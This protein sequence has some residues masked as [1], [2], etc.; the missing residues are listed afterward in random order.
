MKQ[1]SLRH[2]NGNVSVPRGITHTRFIVLLPNLHTC[3]KHQ[4]VSSTERW[5]C[6]MSSLVSKFHL[7]IHQT[8]SALISPKNAS[9][10]S[11][12]KVDS[13][14]TG[15]GPATKNTEQSLCRGSHSSPEKQLCPHTST[16]EFPP[17]L[18]IRKGEKWTRMYNRCDV[19]KNSL[20]LGAM[21]LSFSDTFLKIDP[22][23]W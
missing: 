1:G 4:T 16:G 23:F 3:Y 13:Y 17:L 20:R 22:Q 9:R 12:L 5:L 10:F 18:R 6:I 21:T 11:Q 19:S 7:L 14:F 15:W 8:R 2:H